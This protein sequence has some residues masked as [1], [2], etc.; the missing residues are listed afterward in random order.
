MVILKKRWFTKENDAMSEKIDIIVANPAGNTTILV[1]TDVPV[2]RYQEITDKLLEIDFK[3]GYG[4]EFTEGNYEKEIKAEQVGF[5][6]ASPRKG[7]PAMNMSGL[8]FCGNATRAFAFY[9]ATRT[10]PPLDEITVSISGCDRPLIAEADVKN[11]DCRAQ[12]PI[13]DKWTEM[14]AKDLQIDDLYPDMEDGVLV[15]MDGISHLVLRGV[16][17]TPE[18]FEH[19]RQQIYEKGSYM[20]GDGPLPAL[21]V[22]F[23]DDD[24]TLTPVVYVH[25][26]ATTYFE[27]SCA[28]GTTA[29]ATVLS[30]DL[31]TGTCKLV[32]KEPAGTLYADVTKESGEILDIKLGGL[33]ELSDVIT[34]EI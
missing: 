14:S 6:L 27:G 31:E 29:T 1:L 22:M 18:L 28:S 5:V 9:E 2:N 7:F 34:V 33:I 13:P 8:E 15:E 17:A 20:Y 19:I 24:E 4:I 32:F 10:N 21:G 25:E 23:L 30:R 16:K 11:K 12:M 26:V 3:D